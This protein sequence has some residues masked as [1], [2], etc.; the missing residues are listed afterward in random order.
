MK[1]TFALSALVAMAAT[2]VSAIPSNSTL[3]KRAGNCTPASLF[4]QCQYNYDHG[5]RDPVNDLHRF[6][7]V[8]KSRYNEIMPYRP[9]KGKKSNFYKETRTSDDK[10]WKVEHIDQWIGTT[11][12]LTAKGKKHIFRE[13]SKIDVGAKYWNIEYYTCIDW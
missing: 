1:I 9:T 3:S 5:N 11:V 13:P 4:W 6:Q 8:I 10:L 7:L 2:A 12:T